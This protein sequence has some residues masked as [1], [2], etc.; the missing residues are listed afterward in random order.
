M[1]HNIYTVKIVLKVTLNQWS[2]VVKGQF[3]TFQNQFTGYLTQ[4]SGHLINVV[5]VIAKVY[6]IYQF[7][8]NKHSHFKHQLLLI[9]KVFSIH[10]CTN[11]AIKLLN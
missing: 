5:S 10:H 7:T 11:Y 6:H 1:F 9:F 4:V 8:G 3:K 2:P